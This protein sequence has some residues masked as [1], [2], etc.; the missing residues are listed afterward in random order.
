MSS[1]AALEVARMVGNTHLPAKGL[2]AL[3]GS[4]SSTRTQTQSWNPCGVEIGTR[5]QANHVD[6][7]CMCAST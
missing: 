4:E 6:S 5:V 2:W 7:W 3:G 1:E